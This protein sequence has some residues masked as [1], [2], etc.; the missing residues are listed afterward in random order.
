MASLTAEALQ[1]LYGQELASEPYINVTSPMYLFQALQQRRP[2]LEG[3]E[4][5]CKTWCR[6]YRTPAGGIRRH[7]LEELESRYGAV[8]RAVHAASGDE[9][10]FKFVA[11]FVRSSPRCISLIPSARN[12]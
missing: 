7:S 3:T 1:R 12:G 4:Q 6:K 8:A 11:V 2:A 10:A 5:A 9:S